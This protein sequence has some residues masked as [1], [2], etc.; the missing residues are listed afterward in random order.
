M[1]DAGGGC[2]PGWASEEVGFIGGGES[3][4]G[5]VRCVCV[6]VRERERDG[7]EWRR[8]WMNIKFLG[9]GGGGSS[10][11]ETMN[12]MFLIALTEF[13]LTPTN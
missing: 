6:S 4:L 8:K 12:G 5:F 9:L 10:V 3:E 1:G 2:S 7:T 13:L 11:E